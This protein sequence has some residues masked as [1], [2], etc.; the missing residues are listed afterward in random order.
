M[1]S[2]RSVYTGAQLLSGI[3]EGIMRVFVDNKVPGVW[4]I[5]YIDCSARQ[6]LFRSEGELYRSLRGAQWGV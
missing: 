3:R 1:R 2:R 5:V 4:C 6:V